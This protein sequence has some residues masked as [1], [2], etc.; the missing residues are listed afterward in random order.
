M[1]SSK[2]KEW[3]FSIR[4]DRELYEILLIK[5]KM[6]CVS[7]SEIVRNELTRVLIPKTKDPNTQEK[8]L[9]KKPRHRKQKLSN[10]E[11]LKIR[12][13]TIAR[14]LFANK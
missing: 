11:R 7:V 8:A 2:R 6:R 3:K 14:R 9:I 12:I 5:S 10:F 1:R 13:A 4:V